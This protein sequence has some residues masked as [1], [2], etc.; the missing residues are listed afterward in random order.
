[1]TKIDIDYPSNKRNPQNM[2]VEKTRNRRKHGLDLYK[3]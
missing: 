2:D 3:Y 1:M